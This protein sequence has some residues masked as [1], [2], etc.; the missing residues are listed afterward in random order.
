MEQVSTSSRT[1]ASDEKYCSDCA[2]IIKAKAEICPKC[3]VRQ[4]TAPQPP[5]AF[6]LSPP[7]NKSTATILAILLGALGAHKFYLNKPRLGV[8]YLVFVWTFIPAIIGLIEG[9]TYAFSSDEDFNRQYNPQFSQNSSTPHT[10]R[11]VKKNTAALLAVF[12]GAIGGHKFYLNKPGQGFIYLLFFLTLIPGIISIIE[13]LIYA[14][15]SEETFQRKYG[16]PSTSDTETINDQTNTTTSASLITPFRVVIVL[17][18][19]PILAFD[20]LF[21][22]NMFMPLWWL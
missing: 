21:L 19:L 14:F 16:T 18:A 8:F 15:L 22:S 20:V 9:L 11:I 7:K 12:L 17:C 5:T 4:I 13:G 1:K 3:G 10:P 2:A 6:P